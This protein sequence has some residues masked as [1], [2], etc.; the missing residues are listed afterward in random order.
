MH[1]YEL[2]REVFD[3]K[4]PKQVAADL[5]LS[6]SMVYK[7]A[8]PPN[9][10]AGSGTGNPLD[11]IESLL[12][13]TGD[14]RLVQW[15][16]QRAGGFFIQNPKTTPHP[17]F[18]IPATNQIVQEFAD[19][20]HVIATATADEQITPAESKQ[21]RARWEELKT[22]TEGFVACCEEGNFG[23]IRN[24]V[25]KRIPSSQPRA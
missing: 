20:L 19:L 4:A 24:H 5:G 23:Q 2:L 6:L 16:C 15:I 13:S 1:S 7:W 12:R 25:A 9:T 18:L 14:Q 22:V 10:A 17:H 21:I 8:E 3:Q 11:R